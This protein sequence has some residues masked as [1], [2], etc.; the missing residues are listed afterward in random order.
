[1]CVLSDMSD[2]I[3][4][5]EP[6]LSRYEGNE[7]GLSR[8]KPKPLRGESSCCCCFLIEIGPVG[9]RDLGGIGGR[10]FKFI[11][12]SLPIFFLYFY[13][14]IPIDTNCYNVHREIIRSRS[15][16]HCNLTYF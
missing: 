1:M 15:N 2:D 14:V 13:K 16:V 9:I 11:M 7:E 3:W 12:I 10:V 6:L 8:R 5:G 4:D